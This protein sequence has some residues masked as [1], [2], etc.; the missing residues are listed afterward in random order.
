M[1]LQDDIKKNKGSIILNDGREIKGLVAYN[2]A[3]GIL[4][5]DDGNESKTL[6][7][8][9]VLGFEVYDPSFEGNRI[10]YT[11]HKEDPEN[12]SMQPFFFE[13]LKDFKEF[14]V[15]S[16]K[17][18]L[19]VK[20][21]KDWLPMGNKSSPD[22]YQKKTIYDKKIIVVQQV[23]TFYLLKPQSDPEPYFSITTQNTDGKVVLVDIQRRTKEKFTDRD[24]FAEYL[25][26]SFDQVEAYA[27]E[28]NLSFK[29]KSDFLKIL[30]YYET[31]ID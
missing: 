18:P 20:K 2:D 8:R 28:N 21:E 4:K 11:L 3:T 1:V 5:F 7:S 29:N 13:L 17:E 6:T 12:G 25:G 16:R 9:S 26:S 23:E 31:L 27:K 30:S 10:F 24:L 22:N 15:L 19:N 14:A